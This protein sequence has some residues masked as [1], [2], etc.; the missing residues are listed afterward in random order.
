M[1]FAKHTIRSNTARRVLAGIGY[2]DD[3]TVFING[4]PI[5]AGVNGWDSAHAGSLNE[6]RRRAVGVG[7]PAVPRR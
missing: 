2:S 7:I 5:Y 4:E 1:I 3:V 6:L